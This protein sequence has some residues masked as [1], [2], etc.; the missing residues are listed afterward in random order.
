[1]AYLPFILS[2][3]TWSAP[4]TRPALI[5][6]DLARSFSFPGH[7]R[8]SDHRGLAGDWLPGTH[9]RAGAFLPLLR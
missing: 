3:F 1:M 8:F 2:I 9:S 4:E 5:T 7:Q 6:D